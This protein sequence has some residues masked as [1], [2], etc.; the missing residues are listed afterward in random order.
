MQPTRTITVPIHDC[1]ASFCEAI[2]HHD[3]YSARQYCSE[4]AWGGPNPI[5]GKALYRQI[6]RHSFRYNCASQVHEEGTRAWVLLYGHSGSADLAF[7]RFALVEQQEESPQITGFT[8]SETH[9]RRFLAGD[10]GPIVYLSA[11]SADDGVGE[12]AQKQAQLLAEAVLRTTANLPVDAPVTHIP[13]FGGGFNLKKALSKNIRSKYTPLTDAFFAHRQRILVFTSATAENGKS[14]SVLGAANSLVESGARTLVI[15]ADL[16][17]PQISRS[18]KGLDGHL[19]F[20]DWIVGDTSESPTIQSHSSGINFISSGSAEVDPI[21]V[22]QDLSLTTKLQLL[23]KDYDYILI[24]TSPCLHNN[25]ARS[26]CGADSAPIDSTLAP[27]GV[28]FVTDHAA[29][30]ELLVRQALEQI[31]STKTPIVTLAVNRYD[32]DNSDSRLQVEVERTYFLEAIGR[33]GIE[34]RIRRKDA[35]VGQTHWLMVDRLEENQYQPIG[36]SEGMTLET[37]LSGGRPL[38]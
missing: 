30:P 23:R 36:I 35:G 4:T 1:V 17:N 37:F 22:F 8:D 33:A 9:A 26:V 18:I 24:D 16:H 32:A 13:E 38:K 7:H 25:E 27:F 10:I 19:G 28:V 12:W 5:C 11:L 21:A 31:R 3:A 15:D 34:F 2:K 20:A 29:V 6:K 14:A